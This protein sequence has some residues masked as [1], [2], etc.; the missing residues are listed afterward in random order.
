MNSLQSNLWVGASRENS[1]IATFS[2]TVQGYMRQYLP[3][4][5]V[6]LHKSIDAYKTRSPKASSVKSNL[7]T[8]I[9]TN[10][11]TPAAIPGKLLEA[12][13][14]LEIDREKGGRQQDIHSDL[15][16]LIFMEANPPTSQMLE[17]L[18]SYYLTGMPPA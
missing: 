9:S 12:L 18:L 14:E 8:A 5:P 3:H 1:Q 6:E 2:Y 15:F 10:I 13:E 11:D 7:L 17:R 4:N 16:R